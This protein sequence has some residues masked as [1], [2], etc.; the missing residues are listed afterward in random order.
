ME[1]TPLETCQRYPVGEIAKAVKSHPTKGWPP[2]RQPNRSATAERR[3]A[4]QREGENTGR[5]IELRKTYSC[6]QQDKS[7]QPDPKPTVCRHRKAAVLSASRQAEGTP[8]GSESGA[9][10]QQG[11]PG[12]RESLPSP[13]EQ[14]PEPG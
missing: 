6:G 5:V 14:S 3:C 8:P 11:N 4:K 10:E 7:G 13:W 12:T 1:E 2:G 9:C